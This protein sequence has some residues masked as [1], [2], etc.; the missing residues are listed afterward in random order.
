M[1]RALILL[2]ILPNIV[3]AQ[4][5]PPT[6]VAGLSGLS[7]NK[8]NLDV[9]LISEIVTAKQAELKK[10]LIRR[11]IFDQLKAEN[12]V[13]WE[14]AYNTLDI[15]L[16]SQS[17]AGI[18]KE[19]LEYAA[20]AALVYG[21]TEIYLQVSAKYC[22]SD[23]YNLLSAWNT[24][25]SNLGSFDC[26]PSATHLAPPLILTTLNTLTPGAGHPNNLSNVLLDMVYGILRQN[27]TIK[28]LGFFKSQLPL[29]EYFYTANSAYLRRSYNNNPVIDSLYKRM[30]REIN[31][32]VDNY[33]CIKSIIDNLPN[34]LP[35]YFAAL[36][37]IPAYAT[38]TRTLNTDLQGLSNA[39][40]NSPTKE[41][42]L[43]ETITEVV[44]AFTSFAERNQESPNYRV[45]DLYYIDQKTLPL[46]MKL[47]SQYGLNP[48]YLDFVK[49]YKKIITATLY[50][51]IL[52][53]M[54]V[55]NNG[56]TIKQLAQGFIAILDN[57]YKLD[58]AYTFE[59]VLSELK[60]YGN[61][62][63][64][65]NP[66]AHM[67]LSSLT[68][69]LDKYTVFDKEKNTVSMDVEEVIS[70]VYSQYEAKTT[71]NFQLYFSVGLNQTF[72]TSSLSGDEGGSVG[73]ASEKIG[74]KWVALNNKKRKS[75]QF[76]DYFR[77]NTSY[78]N[79]TPFI[80]DLHFVAYGSG[81]L[82]NIVN[83]KT[84]ANFNKPIFGIG[85]GPSFFNGLDFH[86]FAN[87]AFEDNVKFTKPITG[88][89]F[90]IKITEYLS[91]LKQ[92]KSANSS[93]SN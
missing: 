69:F 16:N 74:V 63:E 31:G 42:G 67:I 88:F 92:K 36:P 80:S 81:L 61:T 44:T 79:K 21:F 73:F 64:K 20:N 58:Q 72:N 60:F 37:P 30:Q 32:L 9:A 87:W 50:N 78:V 75:N 35:T 93:A 14:F 24:S 39:I 45:E 48:K 2:F 76:E 27:K 3:F 43:S 22:N 82:Y 15:L 8:G 51:K 33:Y 17:K 91:R 65:S 29:G 23:L 49:D 52:N 68:G 12:Y 84:N 54:S 57:F 6:L 66:K 86:V 34:D 53:V 83:V 90:D 47:V 4:V 85:F 28:Q 7:A 38:I 11:L 13:T 26:G 1:K 59:F 62:F 89:S 41:L 10:E 71:S 18:Q 25:Y 56:A 77:N 70:Q 40:S 5:G 55:S 19:V 46:V